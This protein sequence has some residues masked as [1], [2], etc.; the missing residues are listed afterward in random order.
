MT[1]KDFIFLSKG[2]ALLSILP[3]GEYN[4]AYTQGNSFL[5]HSLS[6]TKVGLI[7]SWSLTP[8]VITPLAASKSASEITGRLTNCVQVSKFM[9]NIYFE[10]IYRTCR[11]KEWE[12]TY[13]MAIRRKTK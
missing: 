8:A 9:Y 7:Q 5:Q 11:C 1:S 12:S 13:A 3:N 2:R 4:Q 10:L 6:Y